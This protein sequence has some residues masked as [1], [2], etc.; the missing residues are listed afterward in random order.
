MRTT[1]FILGIAL[2]I[3]SCGHANPDGYTITGKV[4]NCGK[5]AD[6]GHIVLVMNDEGKQIVDTADVI[7]GRFKLQGK[8]EHPDFVTM[9]AP[10]SDPVKPN[11]R[12]MFFL[13][14]EKYSIVIKDNRI[15]EIY[16]KGGTSEKL[17][18]EMS[19]HLS[20]LKKKYDIDA[21]DR[22]IN[23]TSTPQFRMEKLLIIRHEFDSVMKAYRDSI[24]LANTPSYF[25][26]YMTS[27]AIAGGENL[28]SIR[29]ALKVYQKDE[30]FK[31]D[32]RLGRMIDITEGKRRP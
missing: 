13:E 25:S 18:R 20:K 21:I 4:K 6:G 8:I 12:I 1:T 2:A 31:D 23:T 16:L 27:Q 29:E 19:T 9:Y 26:L 22:Q 28:D 7:N 30:R 5:W 14:N 24:I 10:M 17:L 15:S 3:V 11:G 32:P